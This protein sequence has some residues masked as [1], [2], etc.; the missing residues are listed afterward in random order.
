MGNYLN[1]GNEAFRTIRR[2]KYIDKT[3]MIV[4]INSTL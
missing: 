2:G 1:L 4:F 3:G